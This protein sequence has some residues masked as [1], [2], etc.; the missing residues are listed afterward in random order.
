VVL[1][2]LVHHE[3]TVA[4]VEPDRRGGASPFAAQRSGGAAGV[5]PDRSGLLLDRPLRRQ[6]L[7]SNTAP[8][9]EPL[10]RLC[11]APEELGVML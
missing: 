1:D 5:V 8:A 4:G 9:S 7:E 11:Y 3:G 10:P 2:G 6:I